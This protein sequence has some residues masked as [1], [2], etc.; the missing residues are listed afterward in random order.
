MTKTL[1]TEG[2]TFHRDGSSPEEPVQLPH[3][4]MIGEPRVAQGGTDNHG[5]F[6]P[7]GKYL[8]RKRWTAPSDDRLHS[9]LF[10]GVFGHTRVLIDG[11]ERGVSLSP[12]RQFEVALPA[13]PSGHEALIEVFVDN[14]AVPNS[15]W[16]T[17][18][19]IY[20]PV[21]LRSVAADRISSDGVKVVTRSVTS[22]DG[23]NEA[24]AD[25][26]V[27]LEGPSATGAIVRL[28]VSRNGQ[29]VLCSEVTATAPIVRFATVIPGVEPWSADTPHLYDIQVTMVVNDI[30]ADQRQIRTGFR[31]IEVDSRHGLRVNG[32]TVLLRGTAVH[33]D[34]G[35]L[36]AATV[37]A[38]EW[39]RARILKEAGFNA[40]RSAHNPLSRAFLDACDALGLYVMDELTDIWFR[41]KTPHDGAPRFRD[42]WADD[43]VAMIEQDRNRPSVIMYSIGNEIAESALPGGIEMAKRIAAFIRAQDPTRP[44][45]IAVNPLLAM[46]ATRSKSDTDRHDTPPERTPA[47]STAAN[48]M[49]AKIGRMM[50]LASTLPAADRAS[51]GAFAAVDIAGYNYGYA[52]YRG[53]RRR[54]PDRIIVGTESMPGD[55]PAIWRRVT[56]VPG[57][58]GDFSW[59]GW[60][61]L[62]EVGLG[63]WS[64]GSEPGGIAK[65]F[66]GILAGCG[67]FDITGG[68]TGML[69]LVQAV[70]GITDNPGIAVR[71]LD[72]AG[73]RPNKTPWL[74][75]DA[76]PGWSWRGHTGTTAEIEVYSAADHVEL[77]LNGRSLGHRKAGP[78]KNFLTRFSAP[79]EEG[80]L[81]AIAYRDGVETG[82]STLRSAAS[83]SLRLRAETS[84]LSGSNDLAYIWVELAD[85]AGTVDLGSDD[86]VTVDISGPGILAALGS[87]SPTT[88]GTFVDTEHRTHR[89]RA[90]AIVRST[91]EAGEIVVRATS[92]RYGSAELTLSSTPAADTTTSE[93]ATTEQ[94]IAIT[95]S[96][97]P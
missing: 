68:A 89:G 43:A 51:R 82:R 39:R 9:L 48:Q 59:T 63:Y 19:G 10:E 6:F 42:E 81:T 34:N 5:G 80:E 95:G 46:M 78:K 54:Y 20:R 57:V 64:Y 49:A 41:R 22:A 21:W 73:Q 60:D 35:I 65:P 38:A 52:S 55:L 93:V 85:E 86:D 30:V 40:I 45:T 70:W 91:D 53:A 83:P 3:D 74:S 67:I 24:T 61:Y 11:K 17:G 1:F 62:G 84:E 29:P 14:S 56:T 15:R 26:T 27:H 28:E 97:T 25:V 44:T 66:P 77:L 13:T 32:T 2:W 72:R 58:I 94:P 75:T 50:V 12:Y 36:G 88:E 96:T 33:H 87:A 23:D 69:H 8:Y 31:T 47:T 92:T 76:L 16:Y 37:D 18:S 71:P 7:G 79:Y 90:L 4:A